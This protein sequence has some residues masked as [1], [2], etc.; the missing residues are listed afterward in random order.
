MGFNMLSSP[1]QAQQ[2]REHDLDDVGIDAN[3]LNDHYAALSID[4]RHI[5][6]RAK[7]TVHDG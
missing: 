4:P 7:L 5:T 3:T 2:G 1:Q 6:L